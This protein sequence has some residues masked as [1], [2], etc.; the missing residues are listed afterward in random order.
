MQGTQNSKKNKVGYLYY[1]IK[2]LAHKGTI[3]KTVWYWQKK[4]TEI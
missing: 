2:N 3:I 1:Q 4:K